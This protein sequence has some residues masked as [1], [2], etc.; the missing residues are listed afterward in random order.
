MVYIEEAH[1]T[2]L[3]Q[4]PSNVRDGVLFAAPRSDEE[5][6]EIAATCV[7]RLAVKIPSLLDRIDNEVERAYTAW[8]DRLY[9]IGADGRV[10]YKSPPGPFGFSTGALEEALRQLGLTPRLA[11]P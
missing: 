9:V 8:P 2:D 6:T 10:R 5:R 7:V 4:L 3:W 11:M 1:P